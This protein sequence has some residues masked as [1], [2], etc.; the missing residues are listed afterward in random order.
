MTLW[1]ILYALAVFQAVVGAIPTVTYPINSQVPPVARLSEYFSYTF[2]ISTFSSDLPITYTLSDAPSWLSLDDGTCTF[3]GTPTRNDVGSNTVT[4]FSVEL[5]ASDESGSVSLNSTFVVSKNPAPTVSIPLSSQLPYLGVFSAPS[6]L[7]FPQSTPFRFNFQPGTFSEY[8]SDTAL[9]YYATT[10]ANTPLPSWLTFDA[11]TLSFSGHTP[12]Y[13]SLIGLQIVASDVEGFFGSSISFEMAIGIHTLGF[14]Q[15]MIIDA[16]PGAYVSFS[17]LTSNIELDG[18]ATDISNLAS[19]TAQTPPWLVFDNSTLVISGHTPADATPCNITI[20]ATDI[21][22]D[23]ATA[24][25]FVGIGLAIIP[26][27]ITS[28]PHITVTP[29]SAL[30]TSRKRLPKKIIA[31]IVVPILLL[32]LAILTALFWYRLRRRTLIEQ[33][34]DPF[35]TEKFHFPSIPNADDGPE[36]A[37]P[38]PPKCLR[39]DALKYVDNTWQS[40]SVMEYNGERDV[41]K[42][43]SLEEYGEGSFNSSA[44]VPEPLDLPGSGNR[45]RAGTENTLHRSKPSWGSTLTSIFPAIRSRTRTNSSIMQASNYSPCSE[46]GHGKRSGR[47]WSPDQDFRNMH[48]YGQRSAESMLNSRDCTISFGAMINFPIL[49]EIVDNQE[50]V[51]SENCTQSSSPSKPMRRRS[52]SLPS[53]SPLCNN[54]RYGRPMSVLSVARG[55][56]SQRHAEEGQDWANDQNRARPSSSWIADD[57]KDAKG[58][59]SSFYHLSASRESMFN[60]KASHGCV[61]QVRESIISPASTKSEINLVERKPSR[62]SGSSPFFG[63]STTMKTRRI[64]EQATTTSADVAMS[65]EIPLYSSDITITSELRENGIAPPDS[66]E[67][68]LRSA[69]EG[70]K[71]LKDYI[72]NLLRRTWTQESVRSNDPSDSLFESARGS[73]S[74]THQL[75]SVRDSRESEVKRIVEEQTDETLLPDAGS[76]WSWETHYTQQ[77]DKLTVIEDGSSGS[78]TS[79]FGTLVAGSSN[80]G[81]PASGIGSKEVGMHTNSGKRLDANSSDEKK[82]KRISRAFHGCGRGELDGTTY[83]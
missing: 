64:S 78:P 56:L 42:A 35:S 17:G 80:L 28:G 69:C 43:D 83:I 21:Y 24:T 45:S 48:S 79:G 2:S 13:P 3:T 26:T 75:P 73:M 22:G 6:T 39:L 74:S 5:V 34:R 62:R 7:I 51:E 16:I 14:S 70:T 77:D 30:A 65:P 12:S 67:S 66:F 72:Q 23:V 46:R 54:G 19:I 41:A 4:A 63:A 49:S 50:E 60:G 8:G 33:D 38:V 36:W 20:D 15:T 9:Y 25:I 57:T 18:Q 76:E 1:M 37:P 40:P 29:I 31:A 47:M 32:M 61:T 52:R 44:L 58:H 11:A 27:S 68:S 71:Q 55:S 10:T 59:R 82:M 53:A 81:S